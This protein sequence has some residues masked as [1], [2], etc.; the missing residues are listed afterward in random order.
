MIGLSQQRPRGWSW[1][2]LLIAASVCAPITGQCQAG[3]GRLSAA[4]SDPNV[5]GWMQRFPPA[6]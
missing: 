4:E 1:V 2:W 6:P 3:S 5:M